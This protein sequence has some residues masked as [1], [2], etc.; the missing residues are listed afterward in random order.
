MIIREKRKYT[1]KNHKLTMRLLH[2]ERFY[3]WFDKTFGIAPI[4]AP[5]KN[6]FASSFRW[7]R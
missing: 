3:D 6:V 5:D 2:G 1:V 4:V 7:K